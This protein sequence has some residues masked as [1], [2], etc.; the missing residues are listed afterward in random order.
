M[1]RYVASLAGATLVYAMTLASFHPW[2][3]ALGALAS[4]AL[5][6]TFRSFLFSADTL[7]AP[8]FTR[9]AIMFLPFAGAIA[10]DIVRGTW[11]VALVVLHLRP[12]NHPG[13]V[14]VPIAARTR[15]GVA[16]TGLAST[17]SPGS[18]LVDVDWEND[19]MYFHMLD[20]AEPDHVRAEFQR[21]YD[22]YQ[23]H[24]FP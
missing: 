8:A 10:R 6:L 11:Q 17:L 16:V 24:V 20:A 19:V 7:P 12:F 5:L 4:G 1:T 21:S 9:R 13:I 2:D 23:R 14:A 22:R 3:L 18:F 15:L